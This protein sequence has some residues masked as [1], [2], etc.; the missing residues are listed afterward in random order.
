MDLVAR[1]AHVPRLAHRWLARR[2][3][4]LLGL[5][6]R[7]RWP[8]VWR[9]K[10]H[11]HHGVGDSAREPRM[12]VPSPALPAV[13]VGDTAL[14]STRW[15]CCRNLPHRKHGSISQPRAIGGY[16][17]P[18]L[19]HDQRLGQSIERLGFD[20]SNRIPGMGGAKRWSGPP[21]AS[22]GTRTPEMGADSARLSS[23]DCT[24]TAMPCRVVPS[25]RRGRYGIGPGRDGV[26]DPR[27]VAHFSFHPRPGVHGPALRFVGRRGDIR[28]SSTPAQD[29]VL[30]HAFRNHCLDNCTI[31][32]FKLGTRG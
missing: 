9:R 18:R 11:Q 6:R 23:V 12:C 20:G 16:V 1:S 2:H 29:S 3:S 5:G 24:A 17:R 7:I 10:P 4:D 21:P 31:P 8:Y 14:S 28:P 27:Q 30:G 26:D 32:D 19:V 22:I 13:R 15:R 25:T